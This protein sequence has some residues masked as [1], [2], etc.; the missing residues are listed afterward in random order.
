MSR[1]L[2]PV[3]SPFGDRG[4]STA[5]FEQRCFQ[6]SKVS[7]PS[8]ITFADRQSSLPVEIRSPDESSHSATGGSASNDA[9]TQTHIRPNAHI[10]RLKE[11]VGG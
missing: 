1:S 10:R 3:G 4:G 11:Q 6:S 2:R 9:R 7:L 8:H 5:A